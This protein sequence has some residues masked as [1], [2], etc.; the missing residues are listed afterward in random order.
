MSTPYRTPEERAAEAK[1]PESPLRCSACD[2]AVADEE[3]A[4]CPKCL[5]KTTIVDSR[6]GPAANALA[7]MR[8]TNVA[9]ANAGPAVWPETDTC[10]ICAQ[11]PIGSAVV[12]LY[13]SK[14]ASGFGSASASMFFR[15]SVCD[16]CRAKLGLHE[17]HRYASVAGLFLGM[18]GMFAFFAGTAGGI[19]TGLAS[20]LVMAGSL[21]SFVAR[22]RKLRANLDASRI[23]AIVAA[24]LPAP[25]GLFEWENAGFYAKLPRGREAIDLGVAVEALTRDG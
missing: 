6:L 22:N 8:E 9:P 1:E 3:G 13:V 17:V 21:G 24:S 16:G 14:V 4:R 7:A 5:R 25:S 18:F 12:Y 2:I 20:I 23:T 15:V 10:P 11:A 19:A